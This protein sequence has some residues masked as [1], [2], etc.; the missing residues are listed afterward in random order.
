MP[1]TAVMED[2]LQ[3]LEYAIQGATDE[4]L[5]EGPTTQRLGTLI[6][7]VENVQLTC[8]SW[9]EK[10]LARRLGF[11]GSQLAQAASRPST[12]SPHLQ[13]ARTLL[14]VILQDRP[15]TPGI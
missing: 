12:A 13:R 2:G 10:D 6:R 7:H 5:Q 11:V 8:W 9:G 4:V 3:V 1:Y 15:K 14:D